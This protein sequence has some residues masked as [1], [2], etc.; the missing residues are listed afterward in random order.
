MVAQFLGLKLRLLGN[1]FR[2]SPLQVFGIIVGLVYG[3][4]AAGVTVAGLAALRWVEPVV[5]GSITVTVGSVIVLGFLLVPLAFGVDGSL[6]PRAFSLFGLPASR[7]AAGLAL[8][9]L[10][11]LPAIAITAI[12]IAQV[13]TWARDP[14]SAILAILSAMLIVV[15]CTLGAQVSSSIASVVLA[16]RRAREIT[17]LFMLIV[18]VLLAPAVALL[19]SVDWDRVGLGAIKP[20]A[21]VAGWTPLGVAWSAPAEAASGNGGVAMLKILIAIVVVGLLWL[22]WRTLVGWLLVA[23]QRRERVSNHG[24]LGWFGR[25]PD[26][27]AGAIAARSIT[28]WIRDRRYHTALL[29]VPTAP[30]LFV[31]V[32]AVA[33]VPGSV[34]ALI[35]VPVM[36]LFLAWMMHNDVAHDSSA[37]WLHL[38]SNTSGWADRLGRLAPALV[39]G[40]PVIAIGSPIAAAISGAEG[41][42]PSLIGVSSSLLFAGLGLSSVLSARFPYPSVRPGDNPFAQPQASGTGAGLIQSVSFLATLALSLP[43]LLFALQGSFHP[44]VGG[45]PLASLLVGAGMGVAILTLG[46]LWGGLIFTRRA[47]ELLAFTLRQ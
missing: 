28:Y 11:G 35:P 27:P 10:I 43:A 47:P 1:I 20:V 2:R 40:I 34:L 15:M 14:L 12:A 30:L 17:T 9:G 41:A 19:A 4:G 13:V 36:C 26:S 32:L 25:L 22:A 23:P 33:G 16:T 39:I 24:G 6:D 31:I 42:L 45:W 38:A 3:L 18:L 37:V 46:V 29:A 5:A 44:G 8:A 21:D 7:L